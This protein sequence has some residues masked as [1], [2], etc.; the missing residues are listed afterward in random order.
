MLVTRTAIRIGLIYMKPYQDRICY[1]LHLRL[2][3]G[4]DVEVKLNGQLY[5]YSELPSVMFIALQTSLKCFK[6][7]L[8]D[9][10]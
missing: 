2:E 1:L 7:N 8:V 4:V 6:R 9:N 5:T 3:L 10:F